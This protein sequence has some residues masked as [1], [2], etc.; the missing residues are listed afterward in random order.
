M[1]TAAR[2]RLDPSL[3]PPRVLGLAALTQAALRG[4]DGA[5]L[6]A[7]VE[8]AGHTTRS[9][10]LFDRAILAQLSFARSEGLTWLDA[11]LSDNRIFRVSDPV[12]GAPHLLGI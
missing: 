10:Y 11:A 3:V 1:I 9:A 12:T 2:P 6:A 8:N 4:A 5:A 7:M